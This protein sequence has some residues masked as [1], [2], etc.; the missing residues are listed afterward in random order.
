VVQA[1]SGTQAATLTAVTALIKSGYAGGAWT[2]K[3]ITSSTA[4]G[5][6]KKITG[7]AYAIND[8]GGGGGAIISTLNGASADTNSIIVK[9]TY[10]GYRDFNCKVDG[11]DYF[12]ED[13]GFLNNGNTYR[14][15][16]L[17]FNAKVDGADYFKIDNAFLSQTGPLAAS[18]GP[19]EAS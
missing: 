12:L 11:A 10:Y 6:A 4:A 13:S 2:G 8:K 1:A 18:A 7:V 16:D 3:G 17:D 15:G 9:Y 14:N 19:L 5:D